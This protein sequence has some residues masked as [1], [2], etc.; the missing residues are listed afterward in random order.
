MGC[1]NHEGDCLMSVS[2]PG[3]VVWNALFLQTARQCRSEASSCKLRGPGANLHLA[4]RDRAGVPAHCHRSCHTSETNPAPGAQN[5]S[6]GEWR[7]FFQ[8]FPHCG[9]QRP[10]GQPNPT[11]LECGKGEQESSFD[12]AM[13]ELLCIHR[14]NNHA[15]SRG[16]QE[17]LKAHVLASSGAGLKSVLCFTSIGNSPPVGAGEFPTCITLTKASLSR[18]DPPA[19]P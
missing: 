6:G 1:K 13:Q 10:W 2:A 17:F 9:S 3:D 12:V 15:S 14:R 7:Y 8:Y 16:L 5:H 4:S 18:H 19:F 11:A